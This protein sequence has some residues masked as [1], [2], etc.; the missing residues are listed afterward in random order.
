MTIVR[1]T[2]D[3]IGRHDNVDKGLEALG[4]KVVRTKLYVGDVARMDDM[5]VSIDLKQNLSEVYSNIVGAQHERFIRECKRA[6][7]A[8][9]R[10]VVLVEHGG[11]ESVQD[12]AKWENPRLKKWQ[13]IHDGQIRGAYRNVKISAK[14]PVSSAQLAKAMQTIADRY[15]VEWRFCSGW[16]TV[17]VICELLGIEVGYSE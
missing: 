7:E 10:L 8:G 4:F 14:P 13:R 15:G 6:Q 1:D 2:R 16:Q 9:I 17:H 12:V 11:I 3:K 5:T